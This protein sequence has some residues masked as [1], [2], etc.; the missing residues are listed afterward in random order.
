MNC[1]KCGGELV[2]VAPAAVPK[3][4][5]AQK[6]IYA[7]RDCKR[8]L[9][10]PRSASILRPDAGDAAAPDFVKLDEPPRG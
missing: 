8:Q 3:H 4:G 10:V 1:P 9:P 5:V 2:F 6:D 7:C